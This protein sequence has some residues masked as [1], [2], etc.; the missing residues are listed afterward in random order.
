MHFLADYFPLLLFFVA[1]KLWGIYTATA[2][3]IAASGAQILYFR[4]VRGKVTPV[5]WLSLAII[6][7]FGGATLLLH[8]ETFIKWK[9]TVLYWLFAVVLAGGRLLLRRNLIGALLPALTLPEPVWARITW[10][11]VAF[12]GAMGAANLYVASNFTTDTWVNFKVWGGIGLFML[13]GVGT[14]ASVARYLP[15]ES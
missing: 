9:P 11:W 1:F 8:D 2:V 10:A 7:V 3:A 4:T 15:E 6:V 12:L 5:H 13:A 14:V